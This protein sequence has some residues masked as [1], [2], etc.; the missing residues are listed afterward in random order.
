MGYFFQ[1]FS[2]GFFKHYRGS[3]EAMILLASYDKDSVFKKVV[4]VR[5]GEKDIVVQYE[6]AAMEAA[7]RKYTVAAGGKAIWLLDGPPD[8]I[9]DDVRWVSFTSPNESW[10]KK[11]DKE[12]RAS[13]VFMP[14]WKLDEL[15]DAA[16]KLGRK[17]LFEPIDE[18]QLADLDLD[19]AK[20]IPRDA[21]I[22]IRF[23]V[24]GGVP[25]VCFGDQ[26]FVQRSFAKLLQAINALTMDELAGAMT[27][28]DFSVK[29]HRLIHFVPLTY[30]SA[31]VKIGSSEIKRRFKERQLQITK[32]MR[33]QLENVIR[34]LPE[35]SVMLGFILETRAYQLL[36]SGCTLEATKLGDKGS[37]PL[38]IEIP[39]MTEYPKITNTF[40]ISEDFDRT[41]MQVV[42]PASKNLESIDGFVWIPGVKNRPNSVVLLQITVAQKH[43]VKA[44]G[45]LEVLKVLGLWEKARKHK[46]KVAAL[47]FVVPQASTQTFKQQSITSKSTTGPDSHVGAI[48]GIGRKTAAT[49]AGARIRTVRQLGKFVLQGAKLPKK[50]LKVI[51]KAK[52]ALARHND[53]EGAV[54]EA[55]LKELE[56]IPQYVWKI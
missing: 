16:G 12:M 47:V 55:S 33:N 4:I 49:L 19:P 46:Q 10:E 28:S 56:L 13:I 48:Y 5:E 43:P 32:G 7:R 25:R 35:A 39:K 37:R 29:V 6:R 8:T 31:T 44:L 3:P 45:Y 52:E 50:T 40:E 2:E 27:S 42:T 26:R 30:E 34:G 17:E 38:K 53:G 14:A 1:R 9:P 21:V 23:Q 41:K 36:Q 11:L 51:K 20:L 24:F 54:D 15:R 18:Y 22:D